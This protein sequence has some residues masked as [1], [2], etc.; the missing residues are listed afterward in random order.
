MDGADLKA[1]DFFGADK[2]VEVGKGVLAVGFGG[3]IWADGLEAVV[4]F[5]IFDVDGAIHCEKKTVASVAC[6]HYAI[7]HINTASDGFE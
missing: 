7:E 1:E 5:M 6:R 2:V 3:A 4:P